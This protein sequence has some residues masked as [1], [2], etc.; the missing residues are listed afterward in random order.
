MDCERTGL[1]PSWRSG[2][3]PLWRSG[4]RPLCRSGLRPSEREARR[5]QKVH[6]LDHFLDIQQKMAAKFGF[7][8]IGEWDFLRD[9]KKYTFG[10]SIFK[11][12][13]K[14]QKTQILP[15]FLSTSNTWMNLILLKNGIRVWRSKKIFL[16]SDPSG[17]R[18]RFTTNYTINRLI[19]NRIDDSLL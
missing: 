7:S 4:L 9:P 5:Q 15:P 14:N 10:K 17:P 8:L 18:S 19:C 11:T 3:R 1:R 2:L 13:C 12:F 6:F 16:R